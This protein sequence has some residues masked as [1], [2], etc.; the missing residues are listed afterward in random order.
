MIELKY[1]ALS[2]IHI[3]EMESEGVPVLD[4]NG[5][6]VFTDYKPGD[7]VPAHTWGQ[8]VVSRMVEYRRLLPVAADTSGTVTPAIPFPAGE[9]EFSSPLTGSPAP[10]P[11]T[12]YVEP[13]RVELP[14]DEF[15]RY[16]GGPYFEL[17]DGTRIK[18]RAAAET[19][20]S[21]LVGAL[22]RSG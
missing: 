5:D 11:V 20:Q 10:P 18:G 8:R 12:S 13:E 1:V 14:S 16:V 2:P 15:P 4:E 7:E 17:S 9:P 22:L 19:A 3:Q 21:Q 6:R